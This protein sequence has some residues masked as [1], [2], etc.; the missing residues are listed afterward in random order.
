LR[1]SAFQHGQ[2][3]FRANRLAEA[4]PLLRRA[5]GLMPKNL[6]YELYAMW[7]EIRV[8]GTKPNSRS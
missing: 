5:F 1:S 4:V 6:E 3:H 8:H 2:I 7:V